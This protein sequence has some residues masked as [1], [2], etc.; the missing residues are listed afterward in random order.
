LRTN[1]LMRDSKMT[2]WS[3]CGRFMALASMIRFDFIVMVTC[4]ICGLQLARVAPPAPLGPTRSWTF[5]VTSLPI[6]TSNLTS[7]SPRR[8][9]FH[10]SHTAINGT[11]SGPTS[12]ATSCKIRFFFLLF[13]HCNLHCEI[14]EWHL[15][16]WII[17][18]NEI[19]MLFVPRLTF[20]CTKYDAF[21][22]NFLYLIIAVRY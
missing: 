8:S 21:N 16:L 4:F 20:L 12:I 22:R 2:L 11:A 9:L 15:W 5:R 10:V 18:V 14:Y 7:T 17:L 19:V 6:G 1:K 13:F 3:I